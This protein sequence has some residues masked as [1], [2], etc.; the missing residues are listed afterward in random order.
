MPEASVVAVSISPP[1]RPQ[2]AHSLELPDSLHV[3][4]AATAV[5][6]IAESAQ[7]Q[8]L[9]QPALVIGLRSTQSRLRI[10]NASASRQCVKTR[11]LPET[12]LPAHPPVAGLAQP[13]FRGL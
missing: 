9:L 11:P 8:R 10:F 5:P 3:S 6:A 4:Y 1:R 2:L 13:G 7:P 12:P